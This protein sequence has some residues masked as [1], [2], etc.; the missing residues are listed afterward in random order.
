[1]NYARHQQDPGNATPDG[2]ARAAAR[3]RKPTTIFRGG[4][5]REYTQLPNKTINDARLGCAHV[6]ALSRL[7]SLPQDWQMHPWEIKK[8]WGVGKDGYYSILKVLMDA[9]YIQRGTMIRGEGGEFVAIEYLV[10]DEAQ[11]VIDNEP[12]PDEDDDSAD[13]APATVPAKTESNGTE[14]SGVKTVA[15][16]P[17]PGLPDAAGPHA[18][19][20]PAGIKNNNINTPPTPQDPKPPPEFADGSTGSKS[21]GPLHNA[22]P[23]VAGHGSGPPMK[24]SG[25]PGASRPPPVDGD[26]ALGAGGGG[27]CVPTVEEFLDAW[28]RAGGE[29]ISRDRV[30]KHWIRLRA[31]DADRAAALAFVPD[32][33][34]DRRRRKWKLCDAARYVQDRPWEGFA[35][36][37]TIYELDPSMPEWHR[38][39]AYFAAARRPYMVTQMETMARQKKPFPSKDRWPPGHAGDAADEGEG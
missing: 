6:G 23:A 20:P 26:G 28:G 34:A 37:P 32:F 33:F 21:A 27:V 24:A 29:C 9:G 2:A 17:Q 18:V 36:R 1:M 35:A 39:K 4:H 31:G 13:P 15:S 11:V 22:A 3:P 10:F 5:R 19:E 8:R 14:P 30:R 16:L 38:W 25:A 7:L 12:P